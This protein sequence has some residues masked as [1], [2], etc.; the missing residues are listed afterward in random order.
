M[1]LASRS[2][3]VILMILA[4]ALSACGGTDEVNDASRRADGASGAD[5]RPS[6]R[7]TAPAT[8]RPA[9]AMLFSITG[10][11]GP[12]AVK[13]D[14]EQDVFFI[15]NYGPNESED[16]PDGYIAR[17]SVETGE[18]LERHFMTGPDATP[19]MEP[20]GMAIHGDELWVADVR[21]VHAF[22]R[23]SGE[24]LRFVDLTDHDPGFLN[25]MA[26][27]P[28]GAPYVTDTG[29]NQV[30][31]VV[32]GEGEVALTGE[33]LGSPNGIALDRATSE[34]VFVIWGR[35]APPFRRWNP[36]TGALTMGETTPGGRFDGVEFVGS[37]IVVASQV[38]QAI[39]LV[40]DGTGVPIQ[41]TEGRPADIAVDLRRLR[42]AVPYIALDR[43]DVFALTEAGR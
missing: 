4:F 37:Q 12:E 38:D 26:I 34:L 8:P 23:H 16:A 29:R 35:D 15:S 6:V 22:D 18:I 13:Y 33:E 39:H 3:P 30:L 14:E 9:D 25:D 31:R 24:H 36:A 2:T 11:E 5:A 28:D 40:T 20:R 10:L 7:L 32:D 41:A 1:H 19:L 17:A 21:G 27:G 42:V 43:V